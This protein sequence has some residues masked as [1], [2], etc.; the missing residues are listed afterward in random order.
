MMNG[1]KPIFDEERRNV[2]RN[3]QEE[4][5]QMVE[6]IAGKSLNEFAKKLISFIEYKYSNP[7]RDNIKKVCQ[8]AMELFTTIGGIVSNYL[9]HNLIFD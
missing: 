4:S 3:D 5:A 7:S 9:Y 8:S 6:R 1:C 2:L